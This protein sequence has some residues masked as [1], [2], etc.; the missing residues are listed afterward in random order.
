MKSPNFIAFSATMLASLSAS[1]THARLDW[2]VP[3]RPGKYDEPML[4]SQCDFFRATR[5]IAVIGAP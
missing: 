2:R 4:I 5:E 1:A 3:I